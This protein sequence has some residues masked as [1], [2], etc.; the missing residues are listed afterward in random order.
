MCQECE[1]FIENGSKILDLGCGRGITAKVVKRYFQA[2]VIGVDVKD[3]RTV[4][5]PFHLIDGENLPFSDNSFDTVMINYVLHHAAN[6]QNLI[7]EAKR[8]SRN[9]II[10]YEDLKE[11]GLAGAICWLHQNTYKIFVPSQKGSIRFHNEYE[12]QD[13]FRN[14]G[15]KVTLKKATNPKLSWIYPAKNILFVLEKSK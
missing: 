2:E 14:L 7:Q 6:P 4:S 13:I 5:L 11:K 15:L 1:P 10:V 9:R 3:Q 8:V 12:W